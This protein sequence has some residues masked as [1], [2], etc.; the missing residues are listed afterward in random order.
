MTNFYSSAPATRFLMDTIEPLSRGR[1]MSFEWNESDQAA[2]CSLPAPYFYDTDIFQKERTSIFFRSWH[3]VAHV[4]ELR[5]PGDFVT[6]TILDQSVIVTR[7]KEGGTRAFHNVCQHRGNR[8]VEAPR[9]HV[10]AITCGY[11]AW[12]YSMD[13][14]LRGAPRTECLAN[15][16]K[17]RHGLKPVRLEIFAGFVYI[18]LDPD[19]QPLADMAPWA[20]EQMR[21]Y[22]HEL[23]RL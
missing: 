23:D 1:A 15:F 22:L 17:T 14:R 11:H 5:A 13:G 7:S 4:N 12:T 19:A 16:D 9:G 21:H 3:L 18:N 20:E 2:G 10:P 8:L 6:Y